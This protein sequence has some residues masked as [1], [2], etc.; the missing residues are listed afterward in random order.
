MSKGNFRKFS[1]PGDHRKVLSGHKPRAQPPSFSLKLQQQV[2]LSLE[3]KK[4]GRF[5]EGKAKTSCRV[6]LSGSFA[7]HLWS[8]EQLVQDGARFHQ[9]IC[10]PLLKE[11][12]EDSHGKLLGL[13]MQLFLCRAEFQVASVQVMTKTPC[14]C[15]LV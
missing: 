10:P 1:A 14:C 15:R 9:A 3:G 7:L 6:A 4:A 8:F 2:Q 13:H 11:G 12:D 5:R